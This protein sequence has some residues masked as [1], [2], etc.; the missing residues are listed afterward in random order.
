MGSCSG[1][2]ESWR[3]KLLVGASG[4]RRVAAAVEKEED[5]GHRGL[6]RAKPS[7]SEVGSSELEPCL[8]RESS[9][10]STGENGTSAETTCE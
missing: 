3:R 6:A 5:G 1:E 4:G 8:R 7:V 2:G 9:V 10:E